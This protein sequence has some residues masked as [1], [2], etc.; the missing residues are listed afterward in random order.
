LN[1]KRD[2]VTGRS[3][4]K[5]NQWAGFRAADFRGFALADFPGLALAEGA[6]AG[7]A[8]PLPLV[9]RTPPARR[10][11]WVAMKSAMRGAISAR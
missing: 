7:R 6:A 3:R 8:V 4:F 10:R 11:L 9:W 2:V 1:D 5:K